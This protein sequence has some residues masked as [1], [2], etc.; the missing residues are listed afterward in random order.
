MGVNFP[1]VCGVT[2]N[3]KFFFLECSA[4]LVRQKEGY[5]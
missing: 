2:A 3:E 5:K 1:L 4:L